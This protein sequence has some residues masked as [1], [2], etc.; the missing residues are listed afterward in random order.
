VLP[1]SASFADGVNLKNLRWQHRGKST[2]TATG[3]ELGF[4]LPASNIR[5][6]VTAYRLR[7]DECGN[8][9]RIYT[10]LRVKSRYGTTVVKVQ[11]CCGMISA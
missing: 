10:R 4:H 9:I 8:G 1:P 6:T 11:P 5:V 2:A 3:S 7:G